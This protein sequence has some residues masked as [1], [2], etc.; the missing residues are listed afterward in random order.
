MSIHSDTEIY[1][2]A[3]ALRQA[4]AP[5]IVNMRR[6]AK[7]FFGHKL[8][9]ESMWMA[10]LIRRMNIARGA[11]KLL[12]ID[13]LFEQ[14]EV[15]TCTIRDCRELRFL[16]N[17]TFERTAPLTESIGRQATALRK[18]FAPAPSPAA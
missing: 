18:H 5:A 2:T 10:V 12:H 7:E 17:S 11:D 8:Y 1:A 4:L 6:D 15:V 16:P 14:L 13:H 3:T 9:D